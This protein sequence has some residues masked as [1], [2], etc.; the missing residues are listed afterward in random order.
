MEFN[1][2]EKKNDIIVN[3]DNTTSIDTCKNICCELD[4]ETNN[5]ET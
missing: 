1:L 5:I 4:D 3:I 2:D